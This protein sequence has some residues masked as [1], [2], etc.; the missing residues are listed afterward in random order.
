[1]RTCLATNR[2]GQRCGRR[3]A[4]NALLCH[5]HEALQPTTEQQRAEYVHFLRDC[6]A[7]GSQIEPGLLL[8]LVALSLLH[9]DTRAK[10]IEML[11]EMVASEHDEDPPLPLAQLTSS[12]RKPQ[13]ARHAQPADPPTPD[14]T[15]M[16][17]LETSRGTIQV[18]RAELD[19]SEVK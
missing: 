18:S 19:A 3:P 5:K 13:G 12:E 9:H 16:V 8:E 14:P 6:V 10:V 7:E 11:T 4:N 15:E 17:T 1:M 2:A